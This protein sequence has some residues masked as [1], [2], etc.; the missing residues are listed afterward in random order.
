MTEHADLQ[1]W[2]AKSN[3]QQYL[4]KFVK[5][6]VSVDLLPELDTEALR[7]IGITKLGDRL[8]LEIA[9]SELKLD[10]LRSRVPLEEVKKAIQHEKP[11]PTNYVDLDS[12]QT[13]VAP[14]EAVLPSR[15]VT[16]ILP[17]G[18]LKKVNVEGCFNAQLIKRKVLKKLGVRDNDNEYDTY[19]HTTSF[20]EARVS[21]LY[22][23]EFVTICFAPDRPEKHRIM[24]TPKNELP[25]PTAAEVSLRILQRM[26]G[27]K[28]QAP[29]IKNF[30][31]QRPPSELI[32]SNLGEYFP[33]APLHKLEATIRNSVRYS[34][35]MLR[36]LN[37]LGSVL[38]ILL[39]R[40]SIGPS[41]DRSLAPSGSS[42]E[43]WHR[44][45]AQQSRTIGDVMMHNVAMVDEVK[46]PG[47]TA[48]VFSR[49]LVLSKTPSGA[50]G[51][52]ASFYDDGR[53]M[54]LQRTA[55]SRPH[56]PV[57]TLFA[58]AKNRYSRIELM[59][60]ESEEDEEE[61]DFLLEYGDNLSDDLELDF[62]S[63]KKWLQGARIG[64]GSFGTVY[65]GM[66]PITGELMAV[67]QVAI[68]QGTAKQNE[69]H[70]SVIEALQR[71]M[72]LLKELNHENIVR[73]YGLSCEE[74]FLNIFLE[75]IPGG[76]VQLM[77]QLYGP[78]EEPL[79]R[80][81]V[82]QVL[83]GLSYLHGVD[84]I[85][86]DIKGANILID[87]KGTAKISDFGISKKVEGDEG[88]G[89]SKNKQVRRASLQGLVYW[90]APEVVKQTAYTK[91]ADIWSV[92][93]LIVEMF[94]GKHPFPKF[95]QMQAIFKIGTHTRP[96]IPDFCTAEGQDFLNKTFE[97]DYQKRPDAVDLLSEPFLT[98]LVMLHDDA[99]LPQQP[100][101][102]AALPTLVHLPATE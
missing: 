33:T 32:S 70:R 91:K 54:V 57:V 45:F 55:L 95:S 42:E 92:G 69:L 8:R 12:D 83:V 37:I 80:N 71:E 3:C 96:E 64:A 28:P 79:I 24:L 35:R 30:F 82:R 72:T 67:K 1:A 87:I 63:G 18:S 81:F 27:R 99:P 88:D 52:N 84:I 43:R 41:V 15:I 62:S 34:M 78:F 5:H 46:N 68:P 4:S 53:S 59:N 73:Y 9:I 26:A 76:S 56:V 89:G 36:R 98:P 6:D 66:D 19:I 65:L 2:L 29:S 40:P 48:L 22:D 101:P 16:F 14:P 13:I 58:S 100:A 11:P 61:E 39:G 51:L 7:E 60:V 49:G 94:T 38:N 85:H 86:R 90:M 97:F 21:S 47:D 44:T 17:D 25:T 10:L 23:V 75:Y 77:L 50:V 102:A 31:G 93:C 74:N 20:G